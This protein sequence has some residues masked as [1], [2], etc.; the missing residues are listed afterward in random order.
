MSQGT[1]SF[2]T[3]VPSR[4]L[5]FTLMSV[6]IVAVALFLAQQQEADDQTP[7]LS[8]PANLSGFSSEHWYLPDDSYMGF[9]HIPAGGFT[10]GSNPA[11]D[12]MAY[13]NERW[14]ATRRQG[15]L[16]LPSFYVARYETSVAQFAA[17]LNATGQSSRA[18][19]GLSHDLPITGIT[20]PEALAYT[21]WL[22]L[23][24]RQSDQTPAELSAFLESGGRV[25]L[26]SEAEWEKA[27]R[28]TEG[29]V[30]PWR[31]GPPPESVNFNSSEIRAVNA[32]DCSECAWGLSDMAGNVWEMTTSPMQP[33]PYSEADDLEALDGQALW[34][35]RGGSFA[36]GLGNIRA[37]GRGGV[38]PGVR[39]D[40]IG[41]RLVI[42]T[43]PSVRNP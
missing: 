28:G 13:G 12:R 2:E 43:R 6:V 36:D 33:Y 40:A 39:N 25:T 27:A 32:M 37:A 29:Q 41:F 22:D 1:P 16:E 10:M 4:T 19:E 35:M 7:A 20:W 18:V 38:D 31:S 9:V 17:Y 15:R 26:P 3:P 21:R 8:L 14:S 23:T 42:S 24:L 11:V 5:G 34:V 30:F